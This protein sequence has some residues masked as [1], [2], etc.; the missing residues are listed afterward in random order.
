MS[1]KLFEQLARDFFSREQRGYRFIWHGGEP[2]SWGL[3]TFKGAL[4]IQR[5]LKGE[6]GI[7]G[8]IVNKIQ[9]NGVLIDEA[10]ADFFKRCK[11]RVGVSLDGPREIHDAMRVYRSG[12]G[13]FVS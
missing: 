1:L 11:F 12:K 13:S 4:A 7:Q 9:T 8:V 2:L 6:L 5:S 3:D 10:W